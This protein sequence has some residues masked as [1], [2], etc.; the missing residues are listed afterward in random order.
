[1]NAK[2]I[3]N[4]TWGEVWLDDDKVGECKGLQAKIEIQKEDVKLC[5]QM[6]QDTKIT[7]WKGKGTL[8]LYKTSSRLALKIK[9]EVLKNGKD[10]RF[11][12]I[13]KLADPDASG[14]ERVVIKNVSFDDLM[15]ADWE[16]AKNGE[17]EAPFTFTD[18]DYLDMIQPE[19]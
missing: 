1:M 10:I 16:A 14:A 11:K 4:G 5:G 9:D 2:R 18:F 17:V 6:A 7:G 3:I 15:L 8:K 19:N 12:I 13:S